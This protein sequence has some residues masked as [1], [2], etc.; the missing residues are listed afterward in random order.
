MCGQ[1]SRELEGAVYGG[2]SL[3]TAIRIRVCILETYRA[4]KIEISCEINRRSVEQNNNK[5]INSIPLNSLEFRPFCKI[6]CLLQNKYFV[7]ST[8]YY[9][10]LITSEHIIIHEYCSLVCRILQPAGNNSR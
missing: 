4:V 5:I 6:H 10:F 3:V 9:Q 7:S 8:I 1:N 2:S